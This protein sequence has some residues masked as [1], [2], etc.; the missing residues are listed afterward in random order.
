[1]F[2]S[3]LWV[4]NIK[5]L[6]LEEPV[7]GL[8]TNPI[9]AK[10]P[11]KDPISHILASLVQGV[12]NSDPDPDGAEPNSESENGHAEQLHDHTFV[13]RPSEGGRSRAGYDSRELQYA[14]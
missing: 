6:N 1:M 5:L 7:E 11:L 2:R 3:S 9:K 8:P 4:Q 13:T 14:Q 12:L 10:P